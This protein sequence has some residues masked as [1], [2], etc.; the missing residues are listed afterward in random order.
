LVCLLVPGE[1]PSQDKV[2]AAI[3]HRIRVG[4]WPAGEIQASAITSWFE[5]VSDANDSG[6]QPPF[7]NATKPFD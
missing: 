3:A 5:R 6:R 2:V 1:E 7:P 4:F